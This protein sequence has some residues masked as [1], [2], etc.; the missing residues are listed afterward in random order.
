MHLMTQKGNLYINIKVFTTLSEVR[1]VSCVLLL[2]N[3]LRISLVKSYHI[4]TKV[5]IHLSF[6][7]HTLPPL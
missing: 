1:M 3:N 7:V 6:T 5:M 4:K 2:L